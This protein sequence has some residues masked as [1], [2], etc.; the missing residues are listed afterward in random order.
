MTMKLLFPFKNYSV[1][2]FHHFLTDEGIKDFIAHLAHK[3]DENDFFFFDS[4][5]S[6]VKFFE[7]SLPDF[8]N[9]LLQ[10]VNTTNQK[11]IDA[12]ITE[13]RGNVDYIKGLLDKKTFEKF[14][15]EWNDSQMTKFNE[16]VE[17]DSAEYFKSE[18]RKKRHLSVSEEWSHNFITNET[19]KV[20]KTNYNFFC[21]EKQPILLADKG[22]IDNLLV[23]LRKEAT[24][25]FDISG[26]YITLYDKGELKSNIENV[27]FNTPAVFVEG[28]HDISYILKAAELL[29]EKETIEKIILR[30]R[31]GCSNL[32]KMWTFYKENNWETLPQKKLLLYDC[33][34]E[35]KN[36]DSS[37]IF[38]R[39]IPLIPDN[40]IN[41][42][43]ENLFPRDIVEKAI[44]HK[45][46]FV[47][48][49]T[50][51]GIERGVEYSNTLVIVNSDEKKNFCEWIC[52][53][54]TPA[55][56]VNFKS[57]FDI[58]KTTLNT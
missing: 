2:T 58:I 41:R 54:G 40:M 42:G 12:Y 6:S 48:F 29:N 52:A 17:K 31:G 30:Q 44:A 37:N 46:A 32:N 19:V 33:D 35:I 50:T 26:K 8:E 56:F 14:I 34:T 21:V 9:E 57:I 18:D 51:S 22:D 20:K 53:N 15:Q 47:D 45:K 39:V 11:T 27:V 4:F 5:Q 49:K 55:D 25:L 1:N 36:E 13:L 23:F 7:D 10:I 28:V 24:L 16:E 43:I 3:N 38:K